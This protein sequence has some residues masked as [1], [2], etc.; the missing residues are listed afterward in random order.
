MNSM[1]RVVIFMAVAAMFAAYCNKQEA[2]TDPAEVVMQNILSRKSVRSYNGEAIPD[3][4]MQ[5]LL[6]FHG[7]TFPKG[8]DFYQRRKLNWTDIDMLEL[9]AKTYADGEGWRLFGLMKQMI[10]ENHI[11]IEKKRE[12]WRNAKRQR[13][14]R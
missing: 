1:K 13:L 9:A 2:A 8:N 14:H 7:C 11:D 12:E 5:N 3:T 10:E 4:V 6:R